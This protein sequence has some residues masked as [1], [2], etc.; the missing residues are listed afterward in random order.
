[1]GVRNIGVR[2]GHGT[3]GP[4]N[5]IT[6][7]QGVRVGHRTLVENRKDI[8]IR[9]GV[10]VIEPRPGM[11]RLEPCFAGCH[12]LNGNGDA[13]GLEWIR[14][15][16]LLSTPIAYTNTHS[17][18]V[19]RDALVAAER[20]SVGESQYW[21][22]PVV[23][24]TFDGVLNDIWGQHVTA[25]HV[26]EAQ[27]QAAS[28]PVAEGSVG[29][30]TGM[31]CHEF[32]GGI[33]TSSRRLEAHEG[34][35]TVGALVQANYGRR[36]ALR[37]AGYPVGDALRE[38][39]SPFGARQRGVPGMGSIVVTLATDAPLL[40]HQ[41]NQLARRASIGL[42]R[43]GGGT[44]YASGDIFVAFSVGNHAIPPADYGMGGERLMSVLGV[45]GDFISP[46]FVAAA[47]AVEEAILNALFAADDMHGQGVH[48]HAL[49]AARLLEALKQAGWRHDSHPVM[50]QFAG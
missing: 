18:G 40:P 20:S 10:T 46:L 42:A 22:M 1:M 21:C 43:V 45:N 50:H 48:V 4:F 2:I 17:V 11:A 32:K 19:V 15:S 23:L 47:D 14:E 41:C 29:G 44:E 31:I 49:G 26:H 37:V 36:E 7:V 9:T 25:A 38:V 35:W 30:G 12:I 39:P 8:S 16:G 24:E 33:G 6:D 34:G 28:G 27:A 5:A 13:T 3:P